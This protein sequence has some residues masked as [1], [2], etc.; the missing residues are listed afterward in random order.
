MTF[1]GGVGG[2][3]NGIGGIK[4]KLEKHEFCPVRNSKKCTKKGCQR[5]G[6]L[7]TKRAIF[8][9]FK[10]FLRVLRVFG[11]FGVKMVTFGG[12]PLKP[13]K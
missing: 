11:G 6:T 7:S 4:P 12:N 1:G 8:G 9:V 10:G 3:Q 2:C 5:G 13:L